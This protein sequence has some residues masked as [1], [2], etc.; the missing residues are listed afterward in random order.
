MVDLPYHNSD[1]IDTSITPN[2]DE[3]YWNG[4]SVSINE[5]M[6]E[7][8]AVINDYCD[9]DWIDPITE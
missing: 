2:A 9:I 7:R 3:Y 5:Y 8:E 6:T 4:E 1:E